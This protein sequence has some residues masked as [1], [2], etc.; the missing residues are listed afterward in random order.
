MA[1]VIP[2]LVPPPKPV[3]VELPELTPELREAEAAALRT[4]CAPSD[5]SRPC[6]ITQSVAEA[7]STKQLLTCCAACDLRR[8]V[9]CRP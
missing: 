5:P 4:H 9:D 6:P 8:Y 1:G 7:G 2:E 3:E